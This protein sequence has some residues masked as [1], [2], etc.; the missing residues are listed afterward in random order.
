MDD[1]SVMQKKVIFCSS[2]KPAEGDGVAGAYP[3]TTGQRGVSPWTG[4]QS[5]THISTPI[6]FR[7]PREPL[8]NVC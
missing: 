3:V 4:R 5:L 8:S 1:M 6:H 7:I 2:S